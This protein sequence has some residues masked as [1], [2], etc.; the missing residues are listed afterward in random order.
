MIVHVY[1]YYNQYDQFL[2]H[3]NLAHLK[4]VERHVRA[5]LS[6]LNSCTHQHLVHAFV[7]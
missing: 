6:S 3:F 7:N 2:N 1:K 4:F 5:R